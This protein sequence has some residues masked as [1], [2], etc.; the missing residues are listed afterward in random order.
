MSYVGRVEIRVNKID[1]DIEII[2]CTFLPKRGFHGDSLI[3]EIGAEGR[4][5]DIMEGRTDG[6]HDIAGRYFEAFHQDYWG[7]WDGEFWI[8]NEHVRFRGPLL[9][10][11]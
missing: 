3:Q 6:V 11:K 2:E 5:G 10:I 4:L 8:E 7:E 9:E 1:D